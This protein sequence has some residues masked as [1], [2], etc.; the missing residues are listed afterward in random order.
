M[1]TFQFNWLVNKYSTRYELEIEPEAVLDKK[2]GKYVKGDAQKE[3][4]TGCIVPYEEVKIYQSGGVI[5]AKDRLLISVTPISIEHS[6]VNHKN[7]RYKVEA[8]TPYNEY[9]DF[10][11]YRLKYVSSFQ[12]GGEGK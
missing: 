8:E 9:G 2:T 10:Y 11:N 7:S 12:K 6:F 1:R 4:R 5:T 3:Q